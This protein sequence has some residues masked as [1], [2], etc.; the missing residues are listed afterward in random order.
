MRLLGLVALISATLA[1]SAQAKELPPQVVQ[2]PRPVPVPHQNQHVH[3]GSRIRITADYRRQRTVHH[4]SPP[5]GHGYDDERPRTVPHDEVPKYDTDCEDEQH[6]GHLEYPQGLKPE[7]H[8][9]E[10]PPHE[11]PAPCCEP[12]PPGNEP[13]PHEEPVPYHEPAPPRDEPPHEKPA[14]HYEPAPPHKEEDVHKDEKLSHSIEVPKDY[15]PPYPEKSEGPVPEHLDG[16]PHLYDL[17]KAYEVTSYWKMHD[18]EEVK[19][20]IGGALLRD[21][22]DNTCVVRISQGFNGVGITIPPNKEDVPLLT[23]Q[24][25]PTVKEQW[26]ALR[27]KEMVNWITSEKGWTPKYVKET[28]HDFDTEKV[29]GLKGIIAIDSAETAHFGM[30]HGEFEDDIFSGTLTEYFTKE[31][32]ITFWELPSH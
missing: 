29:K 27:V 9:D 31:A 14:P 16:R 32:T 26:Y 25:G 23:Y 17:M 28:T 30:Y 11:E 22:V 8:H 12:A 19:K 2:P 5:S 3:G 10:P 7:E 24:G 6:R 21:E 20:H 4:H 18:P 13:P 1:I 15:N